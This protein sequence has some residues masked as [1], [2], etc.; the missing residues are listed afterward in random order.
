MSAGHPSVRRWMV[1]RQRVDLAPLLRGP[2]FQRHHDPAYFARVSIHPDMR[3]LTW[4][5]DTDL[6]PEALM[7]LEVEPDPEYPAGFGDEEA[8]EVRRAIAMHRDDIDF[9]KHAPIRLRA[10]PASRSSWMAPM[11]RHRT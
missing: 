1:L 7:D 3:V 11:A 10:S 6:A 2:V 5:N 8:R 4:P 9:L